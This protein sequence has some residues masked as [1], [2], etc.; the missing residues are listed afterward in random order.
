MKDK[1]HRS[2]RFSCWS[3]PTSRT[4]NFRSESAHQIQVLAKISAGILQGGILF[5]ILYNI[6]AAD[7]NATV[8]EFADFKAIYFY[9]RKSA[10]SFPRSS[11]PPRP[12]GQL[13]WKTAF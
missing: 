11:N 6:Y 4:V 2:Q 1:T 7:P 8:A 12:R 9:P 13:V 10:H 5:P 3:N